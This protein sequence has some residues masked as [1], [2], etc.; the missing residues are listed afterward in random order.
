MGLLYAI[1][2]DRRGDAENA[3][4]G[5]LS[6]SAE[7]RK[8][9]ADYL[10]GLFRTAGDIVLADDSFLT[11]TDELMTGFETADFMEILPSMRL[12][13]SYFTPSEIHDIARAAADIHGG[14][15]DDLLSGDVIDEGLYGFGKM[16]DSLITAQ[17]SGGEQK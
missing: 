17:L 11:M 12:A 15:A 10:R 9:G 5:Y 8:K 3:M 14:K 13:F 6:G 1:E 2:A 4:R 16:L 7:V